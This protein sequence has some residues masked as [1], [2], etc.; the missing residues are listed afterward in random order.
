MERRPCGRSGIEIG[1]Y[2]VGAW[3]FGGEANDYWG[4]Q[5][6]SEVERIVNTA[7]DMGVNYFD[8]AEMYNDG[9]SEIALGAAVRLRREKAIIG[10][11]ISPQN[12][13]REGVRKHCEASL[14]RLGTDYIDIYMVHWP[15]HQHPVDEA[16]DALMRL[17]A[18]GKIRAIGISNFGPRQMAEA[19]ATGA[20]LAVNQLHYSLLSRA[21]EYETLPYCYK[22]HIGVLGYMP[23]LQGILTGKYAT[24]DDAPPNRLRTRHFRGDRPGA[25]HGGPGAEPEINAALASIRALA[26]EIGA[27]MSDVALAWVAAQPGV[28]CVLGGARNVKQLE[29]NARGCSLVLHPEIVQRLNAIT[30]PVKEKLGP[31]LDYWES[32]ENSR[33]R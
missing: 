17:Q 13:S 3:S 27:P 32:A 4:V 24:L 18:E 29:A 6:Q 9:R 21:I 20:Q 31:D 12:C 25:R 2:G 14:K 7:L 26:E 8:T 30:T 1:I 5:E 16:F 15:I 23:L 22:H 33:V 28:T 10:T 19:L 11:K